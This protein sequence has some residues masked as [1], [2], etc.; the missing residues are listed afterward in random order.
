M[1]IRLILLVVFCLIIGYVI[2]IPEID[3][4]KKENTTLKFKND[5]LQLRI[6]RQK[7]FI[8]EHFKECALISRNQIKK[9]VNGRWITLKGPFDMTTE[10]DWENL[11][12]EK[13]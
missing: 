3:K 13:H 5:S 1:Q 10:N 6:A 8:Q 11:L 9:V 2:Q 4:L 12:V 7:V